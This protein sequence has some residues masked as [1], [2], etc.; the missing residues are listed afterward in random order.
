V[1]I[2]HPGDATVGCPVADFK[3][4]GECNLIIGSSKYPAFSI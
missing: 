2:L 4:K 3:F 1:L